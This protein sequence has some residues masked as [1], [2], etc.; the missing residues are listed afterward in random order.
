MNEKEKTSK[1]KGK[2]KE[3]E[4][5]KEKKGILMTVLGSEKYMNALQL[6][7]Q[8]SVH[9][10]QS[11]RPYIWQRANLI[12]VCSLLTLLWNNHNVALLLKPGI[13]RVVDE[14]LNRLDS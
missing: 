2:R 5:E 6:S 7:H 8:P 11:V 1:G 13:I 12:T 4:K 10:A 14:K 9:L 3:E